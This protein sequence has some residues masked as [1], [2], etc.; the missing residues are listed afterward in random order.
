[1][2]HCVLHPTS[3][4]KASP[5]GGGCLALFALG[6][7]PA[8]WLPSQRLARRLILW[9]CRLGGPGGRPAQRGPGP[10]MGPRWTLPSPRR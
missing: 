3:R 10:R 4:L 1:M 2:L 5:A 9:I 8:G 6:S 7:L